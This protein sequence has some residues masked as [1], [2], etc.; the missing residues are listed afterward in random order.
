MATPSSGARRSSPRSRRFWPR[1]SRA[2]VRSSSP[3]KP[4]SARRCSGRLA[5]RRPGALRPR[6]DLPRRRGRGLALVRRALRSARR[7]ARRGG[8]LARADAAACARGCA[9]ARRAGRGAAGSHAIGVAVLDVLRALAEHGPVLVALDDVQW[10]D[11]GFCR[12]APDRPSPPARG[13]DRGAGHPP[14]RHPRSRP[15]S[16]SSARSRMSGSS[17][18]RSARSARARSQSAQGAAGTRADAA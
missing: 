16:S 18:S 1:S 17:G 4:A 11:S 12:R 9:P 15:P 3:V 2:R 6:S 10:L 13:A 7:G 5:S 8:A 14:D